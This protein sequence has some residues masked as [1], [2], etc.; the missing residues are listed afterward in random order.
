M[1]TWNDITSFTG[2]MI[3]TRRLY[4][5][6]AYC[7]YFSSTVISCTKNSTSF[8][9]VLDQTAFFPEGGGQPSDIGYIDGKWVSDVQIIDGVIIHSVCEPVT[10]GVIV[11]CS[12]DW[13]RRFSN[14]QN[15]SGE[16]IVSGIIHSMFGY[17]NIGFHLCNGL[18]TLDVDGKISNTDL[19]TIEAAANRAVYENHSVKAYYPTPEELQGIEYRSK[20]DGLK[21]P[22]I[23]IIDD[24]D[25]CACCAPHVSKT[26]EI[27]IIKLLNSYPNRGG[28]R[29]EMLCGIMALN[30]YNL[31]H[32]KNA[33]ISQLLSTTRYSVDSS[34]E[35]LVNASIS[36]DQELKCL[37]RELA[38]SKLDIFRF[39]KYVCAF[40]NDVDFEPLTY[41]LNNLLS[42][43]KVCFIFSILSD[44]SIL[45]VLGSQ[46]TDIRSYASRLNS[47]FSGRGGGKANYAQG[48]ITGTKQDVLAFVNDMILSAN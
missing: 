10:P 3:M 45:Y 23:V 40:V 14:M 2:L 16:H 13:E 19:Y 15:H 20:I 48:R 30:D 9:V 22:R 1:V 29:I 8:S 11:K 34:V 35:K 42:Q 37:R 25:C 12:I 28:T 21:N 6:D 32:S 24:C 44:S 7:K 38:Y 41:C 4:E 46:E 27:G 47:E 33:R 36:K 5:E 18:V 17:N 39:D 26:G 43:Y 31:L